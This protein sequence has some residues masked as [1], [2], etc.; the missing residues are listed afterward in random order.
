MRL[1]NDENNFS[2]CTSLF[3]RFWALPPRG[4]S[5]YDRLSTGM[6]I[7]M[8]HCDTLLTFVAVRVEGF[9]QSREGPGEGRTPGRSGSPVSARADSR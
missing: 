7:Y 2:R 1:G 9:D 3:L 6:D 4:D 5:P 8:L